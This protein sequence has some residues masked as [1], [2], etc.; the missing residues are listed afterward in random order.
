ML[1]RKNP[2][3]RVLRVGVADAAVEV[4]IREQELRDD[5]P[6]PGKHRAVELH[7]FRLA[8]GRARLLRRQIVGPLLQPQ[9]GEPCRDRA[10]RDD[11]ALVPGLHQPGDFRGEARELA[12]LQRGAARVGEDA[13]TEFNDDALGLFGHGER[14]A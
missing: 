10:A 1:L 5:E 3:Q 6:V 2:P 13:G 12:L 8:D 7:E 4:A 14:A 11:H 9:L